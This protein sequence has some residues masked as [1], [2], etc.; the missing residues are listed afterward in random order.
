MHKK[1]WIIFLTF[2][3]LS[4]LGEGFLQKIETNPN[5][6]AISKV[7]R[8]I[9]D[10]FF[11]KHTQL[12]RVILFKVKSNY[13]LDVAS[14]I[15]SNRNENFMFLVNT[16]GDSMDI[17]NSAALV[18]METQQFP[19]IEDT[20]EVIRTSDFPIKIFTFI[21][22]LTFDQLKASEVYRY[23]P[24]LRRP[25]SS[26]FQY[27]YFI[28][29]EADTVT[30]STVEWFSP[31]GCDQ[32]YLNKLNVFKKKSQKWQQELKNHEKFLEYHNCELV[33]ALPIPK[34]DYS[35]YNTGGYALL[36]GVNKNFTIHGITP[37]IFE[38]AGKFY[39]FTVDYQPV[40]MND[41]WIKSES[42][43]Q[44]T[45]VHINNRMKQPHVH[46]EVMPLVPK[47]LDI[48]TSNVVANLDVSLFVTPAEKYTPYE[49]F[50]LPFDMM[51]WI[52]VLTTF[53][54]TFLS[55][56]F[57]NHFSKATQSLVY[58]HNVDTPFWNVISIFFG[59]SQTR[60]PNRNFSRFILMI[61]IYFCLIFRT[62]FQSKFFEFMTSEPR[63]AL[64]KTLVDLIDRNYTII[65]IFGSICIQSLTVEKW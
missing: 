7:F 48:A 47:I 22:N 50:L 31:Y 49:K 24:S 10:K 14:E 40:F 65:G 61:F 52:L 32:P 58:G 37:V 59:I 64:P 53:L 21:Q 33:M 13:L 1:I 29:N 63:K 43:T 55:I 30:L 28:T 23:Y 44:V 16:P 36:I 20:H 6:L 26:I 4:F 35:L 54:V 12:C 5:I 42:F 15:L 9:T 8:D 41:N 27:T 62:C 38:I 34:V 19:F 11:S 56:F 2:T 45:L 39:N 17:L 3:Y 57:I 51:T 46:F 25:D 60:L 18:F